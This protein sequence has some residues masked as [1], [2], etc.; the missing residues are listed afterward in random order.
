MLWDFVTC[1]VQVG[2]TWEQYQYLAVFVNISQY[3]STSRNNL[4]CLYG[5]IRHQQSKT[6]VRDKSFLLKRGVNTNLLLMQQLYTIYGVMGSF[7]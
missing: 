3:L 4:H 1:F 6:W 2:T 7:W 5:L